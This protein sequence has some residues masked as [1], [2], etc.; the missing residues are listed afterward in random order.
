[1]FLGQPGGG[2]WQYPILN[3]L[4]TCIIGRS[5]CSVVEHAGGGS[6]PLY[7]A[8]VNNVASTQLMM[9]IF[10]VWLVSPMFQERMPCK[11]TVSIRSSYMRSTTEVRIYIKTYIK[12]LNCVYPWERLRNMELNGV[13]S[14][15]QMGTV[16]HVITYV[17]INGSIPY[18]VLLRFLTEFI[19]NSSK[20][21][22][23]SDHISYITIP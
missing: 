3:A 23:P 15:R 11:Q 16:P 6:H 2:G 14:Y 1:M 18:V 8:Y 7:T 20:G 17:C 19:S 5:D 13:M 10:Y 12:S 22:C 21:L 4:R 9:R